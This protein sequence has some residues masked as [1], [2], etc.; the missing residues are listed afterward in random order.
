LLPRVTLGF[1]GFTLDF[2]NVSMLPPAQVFM[3][4]SPNNKD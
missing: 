4:K 1:T 3:G 2:A